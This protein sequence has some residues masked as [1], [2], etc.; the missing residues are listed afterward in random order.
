MEE[1]ENITILPTKEL[2]NTGQTLNQ[3]RYHE[4]KITMGWAPNGRDVATHEITA[5]YMVN[6]KTGEFI[7]LPDSGWEITEYGKK[8]ERRK[9]ILFALV[10]CLVMLIM[11]L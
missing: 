1:Y 10:T 4:A 2:S 3:F 8:M 7:D 6:E 9:M 11:F 5:R